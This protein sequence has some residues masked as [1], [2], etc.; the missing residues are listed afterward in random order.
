V[1]SISEHDTL[2]PFFGICMLIQQL[3]LKE[4]AKCQIYEGRGR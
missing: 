2:R 4:K 3:C 1:R